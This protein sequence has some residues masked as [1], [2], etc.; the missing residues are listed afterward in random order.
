MFILEKHVFKINIKQGPVRVCGAVSM[1]IFHFPALR[2]NL[3]VRRVKGALCRGREE[4]TSKSIGTHTRRICFKKHTKI[5]IIVLF[6]Q[7][8]LEK[9]LDR[10]LLSHFLIHEIYEEFM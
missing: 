7:I 10:H 1:Y 5:K 8:S 3:C 6:S 9:L 4:R 2:L